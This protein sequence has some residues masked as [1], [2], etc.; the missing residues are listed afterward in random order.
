M[1]AAINTY[2]SVHSYWFP[3]NNTEDE[4]DRAITP[5][6]VEMQLMT[7]T[8]PASRA[9]E[10]VVGRYEEPEDA[11]VT[12]QPPSRVTRQTSLRDAFREASRPFSASTDTFASADG[13]K[14]L[15]YLIG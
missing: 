6:D 14:R 11:A 9:G 8:R 4:P 15:R 13:E 12:V 10:D 7:S 5:E 3:A 2:H 1:Q